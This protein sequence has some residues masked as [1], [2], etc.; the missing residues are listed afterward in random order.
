MGSSKTNSIT[1]TIARSMVLILF[2]TIATTI[3]SLMTLI[4]SLNDAEAI[5]TAGSMRM[6]SYRLA[7]DVETHSP[8]LT[9]H[10]NHFED[11]LYSSSMKKLK[12]WSVPEEIQAQYT[13]IKQRWEELRPIFK[14][15]D[16][17]VFIQ[18]VAPFVNRIDIFVAKLQASSEYKLHQLVFIG[19]IGLSTI[20]CIVF[21]TIHYTRLQIVAPLNDLV[22][23]CKQVKK[24]NFQF[25]VCNKS[26]NELGILATTF[27][28][29]SCELEQLYDDLEKNV[30]EKTR[31]LRHTNDSLQ[32]LY[33]CSQQL[34][35]S[36]LTTEQFTHVL[37]TMLEI[38]GL[39]SAKLII[40]E[41]QGGKTEI[42]VGQVHDSTWHWNDLYVDD[43]LMGQLWW[44]YS[45]PCPDQALIEN[46]SHII[47]RGIY[48]NQAQKQ[49]E[50]LLLMEERATIARELHDSLA[51]SLSYLKIQLALLKRELH[52]SH[53][54]ENIHPTVKEID[55]GLGCAYTQLR[56]LLNTFRLTIK[57]ANFGEALNQMLVPL[58]KQTNATLV[59][60]NQLSSI[61]LNA[62]QQVH[63]LQIIREAVLNAIKHAEADKIIIACYQKGETIQVAI[64]DDGKGFDTVENKCEHYGLSI[65]QERS[66][67]LN[68]HLEIQ[69]ESNQG[70]SINLSFLL[71]EG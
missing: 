13:V 44:Q 46:I 22:D 51:Q 70:S 21:Y 71:Q 43:R 28:K 25:Q 29:M 31:R 42:N 18:Y 67:R 1:V 49:S 20:L 26:T 24:R 38:D 3:L 56:E 41:K 45:L 53:H 54:S 6:Q 58:E 34:S 55:R 5:N 61:T 14:Q 12:H 2:I 68:G 17:K 11:S 47:A 23:A 10:I 40:E 65:M 19:A 7:F 60:N 57:D 66:S 30:A 37:E 69:S 9:K 27:N 59:I 62:H 35:V 33:H 39:T 15:N 48:Y 52:Q 4:S 50:H 16:K 36:R 64:T 63:L 8:L 32:V